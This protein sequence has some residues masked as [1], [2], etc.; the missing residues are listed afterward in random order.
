MAFKNKRIKIKRDTVKMNNNNNI[1]L[2]K[3]E[4]NDSNSIM[5]QILEISSKLLSKI[6]LIEKKVDGMEEKFCG[7]EEMV[8][9][10]N[11]K[12]NDH[13]K[14]LGHI[15]STVDDVND[16]VHNMK[17]DLDIIKSGKIYVNSFDCKELDE[18]MYIDIRKSIGDSIILDKLSFRDH[19]SIIKLM[20]M[21]FKSDTMFENS[22]INY[23]IRCKGK[24]DFEY[25]SDGKWI[26]DK[27]GFNTVEIIF[28]NF[29]NLFM[30]VNRFPNSNKPSFTA[31]DLIEN[32]KFIHTLSE[33]CDKHKKDF[34]R[35]LRNE[36]IK[37]QN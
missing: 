6:D 14:T 28:R 3:F 29:K 12:I 35:F 32:Q 24:I 31:S 5:N 2:E 37:N 30:C 1:P 10:I 27:Y 25:F 36:L 4:M 8:D 34:K 17:N 7:L 20:Q 21:Y 16:E 26:E 33:Y 9:V 22:K 15:E 18:R 23:P 13:E 19:R 11:D